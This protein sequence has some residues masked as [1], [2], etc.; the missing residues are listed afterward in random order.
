MLWASFTSSTLNPRGLPRGSLRIFTFGPPERRL[1]NTVPGRGYHPR[2]A[3]ARYGI[4]R[5]LER[6][7]VETL[8]LRN[9]AA[10][11]LLPTELIGIFWYE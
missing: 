4:R 3:P 9:V 11:G 7:P 8:V 5:D 2:R 10:G 6:Q 1:T